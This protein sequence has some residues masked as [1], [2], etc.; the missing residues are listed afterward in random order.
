MLISHEDN[1]PDVPFIL[2]KV[3]AKFV[4]FTVE[5]IALLCHVQSAQKDWNYLV[6]SKMLYQLPV[7]K[8]FSEHDHNAC[9]DRP[10]LTWAAGKT[11]SIV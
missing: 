2:S 9:W 3:E 5:K 8:T 7:H 6:N 1:G 4:R 10:L 11:H